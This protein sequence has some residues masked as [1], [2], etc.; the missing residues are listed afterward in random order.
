MTPEIIARAGAL[1]QRGTMRNA[2]ITL[3]AHYFAEE[4]VPQ[5]HA[6]ETNVRRRRYCERLTE[7]HDLAGQELEWWER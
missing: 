3:E 1:A 4:P 7:L 6:I 5:P 2:I